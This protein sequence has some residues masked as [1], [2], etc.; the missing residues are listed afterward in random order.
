M[1]FSK[2]SLKNA[3][4]NNKHFDFWIK[5]KTISSKITLQ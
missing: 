5:N 2:L 1:L 3:S 4:K